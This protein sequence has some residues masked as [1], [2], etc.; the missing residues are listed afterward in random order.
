MKGATKMNETQAETEEKELIKLSYYL[1]SEQLKIGKKAVKRLENRIKKIENPTDLQRNFF[2]LYLALLKFCTKRFN[3]KD[4][5]QVHC[6]TLGYLAKPFCFFR[7]MQKPDYYISTLLTGEII[8]RY[9]V[10]D[11]CKIDPITKEKEYTLV[12][13]FANFIEFFEEFHKICNKVFKGTGVRSNFLY[14]IP[15]F[16]Y[17]IGFQIWINEPNNKK[18]KPY[19]KYSTQ[20]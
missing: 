9:G 17:K 12:E 7:V 2:S 14:F 10:K 3:A 13:R 8:V 1:N 20:E 5:F 16:M 4:H 11:K 15:F 18:V 6:N 19:W